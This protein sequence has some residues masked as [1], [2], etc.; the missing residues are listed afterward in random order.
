MSDETSP[1]QLASWVELFID[2][3]KIQ[4]WTVGVTNAGLV[5]KKHATRDDGWCDQEKG[6]WRFIRL[7]KLDKRSPKPGDPDAGQ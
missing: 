5:I 1:E 6:E 2:N 4:G 7:P 3:L